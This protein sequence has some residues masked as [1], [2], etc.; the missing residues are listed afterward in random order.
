LGVR[1][2]ILKKFEYQITT[3]EMLCEVNKVNTLQNEIE[4]KKPIKTAYV[5]QPSR[6][7]FFMAHI[8]LVSKEPICKL[9]C[10]I[11]QKIL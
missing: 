2:T 11:W 10:Y 4:P 8:R 3:K 6:K 7:K 1:L 9:G 5:L